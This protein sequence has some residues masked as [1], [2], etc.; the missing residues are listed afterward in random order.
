MKYQKNKKTD[1]MNNIIYENYFNYLN[2][3]IIVKK[4]ILG[5]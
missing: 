1:H 5:G 2:M 3:L 4:S